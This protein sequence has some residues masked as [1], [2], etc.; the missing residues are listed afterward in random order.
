MEEKR[1]VDV[2]FPGKPYA[3][4]GWRS[5]K[6]SGWL[7]FTLHRK[8]NNTK[9]KNPK[10]PEKY[11]KCPECLDVLITSKKTRCAVCEEKHELKTPEQPALEAPPV[12]IEATPP[13]YA[14]SVHEAFRTMQHAIHKNAVDHGWWKWRWGQQHQYQAVYHAEISEC[15]SFQEQVILQTSIFQNWRMVWLSWPML[16]FAS[17]MSASILDGILVRL[18][19]K[20]TNSTKTP[21]QTRWEGIL[22]EWFSNKFLG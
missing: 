21:I 15:V 2:P 11:I 9:N 19:W 3:C 20:N 10:P 6:N 17:W 8:R 14:K 22:N 18:S 1:T 12:L 16:W 13:L 5:L 7:L 4:L